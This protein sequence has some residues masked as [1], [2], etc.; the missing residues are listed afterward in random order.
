[1]RVRVPYAEIAVLKGWLKMG[2]RSV[3]Y[4]NDSDQYG[5]LF[6]KERKI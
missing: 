6:Y 2:L 4:K 5:M 1:M 3:S